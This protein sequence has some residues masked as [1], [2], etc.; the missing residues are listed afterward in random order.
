MSALAP[1]G[2]RQPCRTSQEW[3]DG[4]QT[5]RMLGRLLLVGLASYLGLALVLALHLL[6]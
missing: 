5:A 4:Q 2:Q 3:E 1:G 6:S